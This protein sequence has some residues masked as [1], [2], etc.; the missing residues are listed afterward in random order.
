[1][2]KKSQSEYISW[3]LILALIV[4]ISYFLFNW[5]VERAQSTSED[6]EGQSDEAVCNEIG[7]SITGACQTYNALIINVTNVNNYLI[8]GIYIKTVGLYPEDD[9]Y[10]GTE[11]IYLEIY[12]DES[13]QIES[14]KQSTFSQLELVPLST[15]NKKYI[16]C[17]DKSIV[18]EKD[19]LKQC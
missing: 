14:L 1:M 3:I 10:L 7:I 19:N 4:A 9:E 16:Y 17:E 15:K 13:E 12:P 18:L 5:S 2:Y 8:E 6:L 11:A